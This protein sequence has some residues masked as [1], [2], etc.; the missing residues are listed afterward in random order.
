MDRVEALKFCKDNDIKIK[1]ELVYDPYDGWIDKDKSYAVDDK[2]CAF[3]K[4]CDLNKADGYCEQCDLEC[5][6]KQK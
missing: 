6:E 5:E 1:G 4:L 3:A 2:T